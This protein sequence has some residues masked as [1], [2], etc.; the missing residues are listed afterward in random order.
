MATGRTGQAGHSRLGTGGA[1]VGSGAGDAGEA[2]RCSR[3]GRPPGSSS[4]PAR[5]APGRPSSSVSRFAPAR[6]CVQALGRRWAGAGDGPGSPW[7]ALLLL[8]LAGLA[9]PQA[10]LA[11]DTVTLVSNRHYDGHHL[12]VTSDNMNLDV[13]ID[14]AGRGPNTSP[15]AALR[16]RT[17]PN[18]EGYL[19]DEFVIWIPSADS[20]GSSSGRVYTDD[21][22][23]RPVTQIATLSGKPREGLSVLSSASGVALSPDT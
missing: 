11:Q 23:G 8:V 4:S 1:R 10:V 21:G 16:F 17:G 5:S 22:G 7:G 20:V 2:G 6:N 19:L 3:R 18:P 15:R 14:A 13:D 9:A 12:G